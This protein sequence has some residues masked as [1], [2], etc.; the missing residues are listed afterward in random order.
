MIE[1]RSYALSATMVVSW[2]VVVMG[3]YLLWL[4]Y[5]GRIIEHLTLG[6]AFIVALLSTWEWAKRLERRRRDTRGRLA[7]G[8]VVGLCA[9]VVLLPW[10]G[11]FGRTWFAV[12]HGKFTALAQLA[13][14]MK[15]PTD[16]PS[17]GWVDLPAEFDLLPFDHLHTQDVSIETY[18]GRVLMMD[19]SDEEVSE[20]M[21]LYI[22]GRPDAA[23]TSPC[24]LTETTFDDFYECTRLGDGWWWMARKPNYPNVNHAAGGAAQRGVRWGFGGPRPPK[25]TA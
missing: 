20:N 14:E 15:L 6:A 10:N 21:F 5:Y 7:I 19:L 24:D 3:R 11:V 8:A 16:T 22:Y 2:L 23:R 1:K 9:A 4:E 25:V 18:P 13:E 17:G 12:H